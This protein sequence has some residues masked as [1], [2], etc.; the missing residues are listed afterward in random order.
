MHSISLFW[1]RVGIWAVECES[2]GS[3]YDIIFDMTIVPLNYTFP[4]RGL[5]GEADAGGV[6]N[7]TL[8]MQCGSIPVNDGERPLSIWVSCL[9]RSVELPIECIHKIH[10]QNFRVFH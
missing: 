7:A 8:W 1:S 6:S 4:V 2:G 10:I 3:I 9:V 5:E